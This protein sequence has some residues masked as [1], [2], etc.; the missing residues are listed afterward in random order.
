MA[1][2]PSSNH[3]YSSYHRDKTQ[4]Y[5]NTD[6]DITVTI[7]YKEPKASRYFSEFNDHSMA[8]LRKDLLALRIPHPK[9]DKVSLAS[10]GCVE[11]SWLGV[12]PYKVLHNNLLQKLRP[13][14]PIFKEAFTKAMEECSIASATFYETP[15]N[16]TPQST[17]SK[18][19]P[20]QSSGPDSEPPQK[21]FAP[22]SSSQGG[23]AAEQFLSDTLKTL[24]VKSEPVD[25]EIPPPPPSGD[26]IS[27]VTL[28]ARLSRFGPP[29]TS[30]STSSV[31]DR[32]QHAL[33]AATT[34]PTLKDLMG[35]LWEVRKILSSSA[36]KE[37][38]LVE[39]IQ[40]QHPQL[41]IPPTPEQKELAVLKSQLE[42]ARA[43]AAAQRKV[44][45]GIQRSLD[46]IRNE[47]KEPFIVPGLI[48]AFL[49]IS[50]LAAKVR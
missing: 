19:R 26:S 4:R 16:S 29:A 27:S 37:A 24:A 22:A 44:N 11:F 9:S 35:E 28:G 49:T 7:R 45:E 42:E 31:S 10:Y 17:Y 5:W 18:K 33:T 32:S 12:E 2:H 1:D 14:V 50:N 15:S 30:V 21:R 41:K 25:A 43:D 47:S 38:A 36:E 20:Y 8:V 6:L 13:Q 3:S 39:K 34:E 40:K 23:T 46:E 48:D